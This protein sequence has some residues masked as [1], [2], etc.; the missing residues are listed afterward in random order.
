L[1]LVERFAG[2]NL[3]HPGV[4]PLERANPSP[5]GVCPGEGFD[6]NVFCDEGISRQAT[7]DPNGSRQDAQ[8][9]VVE[10]LG[11]ATSS[12][13]QPIKGVERPDPLTW[14]SLE[15]AERGGLRSSLRRRPSPDASAACSRKDY[16]EA[17]PV[18]VAIGD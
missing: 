5:T 7:G 16:G 15:F 17:R 13:H 2:G 3:Q 18:Y 11:T 10:C 1:H 6:S 14:A 4:S 8:E 12:G 9:E